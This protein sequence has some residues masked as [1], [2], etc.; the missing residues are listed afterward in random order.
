MLVKRKSGNCTV[1]AN[2]K[3]RNGMLLRQ[4]I[5]EGKSPETENK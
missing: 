3:D 2:I 5:N 1:F 4:M